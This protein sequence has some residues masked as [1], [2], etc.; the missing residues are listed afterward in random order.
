MKVG[1]EHYRMGSWKDPHSLTGAFQS[2]HEDYE[3]AELSLERLKA[4][5][6]KE[7]FLV[8]VA[9]DFERWNRWEKGEF[10]QVELKGWRK[11]GMK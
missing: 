2:M 1:N 8:L 3:E 6:K 9:H 7:E 11:R 5:E 4:L 10:G